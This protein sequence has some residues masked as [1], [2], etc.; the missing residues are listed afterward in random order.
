MV[1]TRLSPELYQMLVEA[2][3]T[4]GRSISAEMEKRI[5]KSFG[6]SVHSNRE[7]RDL[8]RHVIAAFEAGGRLEDPEA[9][10]ERWIKDP[11][12]YNRAVI[13]AFEALLDKHPQPRFI[14]LLKIIYAVK[15]RLEQVWLTAEKDETTEGLRLPGLDYPPQPKRRDET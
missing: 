15:T 13:R 12:Q 3:A 8:A 5:E 1:G 9:P 7:L 11:L 14:D 4:N 6:S 10:V 2:A